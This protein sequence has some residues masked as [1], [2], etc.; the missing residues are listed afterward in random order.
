MSLVPLWILVSVLAV[1]G[2]FSLREIYVW[3]HDPVV[4]IQTVVHWI[5]NVEDESSLVAFKV[6]ITGMS[7]TGFERTAVP[8]FSIGDECVNV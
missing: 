4:V 2:L 7:V 8:H 1:A 5:F 6:C 3:P